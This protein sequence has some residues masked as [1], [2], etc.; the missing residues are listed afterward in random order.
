MIKLQTLY[1]SFNTGLT[2][3]PRRR[4]CFRRLLH[5]RR[6]RRLF[7]LLRRRRRRLLRLGKFDVNAAEVPPGAA[8][9]SIRD[10]AF[11]N[12]KSGR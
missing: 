6:R 10:E 9:F 8:I 3:C 2:F 4:R 5:R 12:G 1:T 11:D 7:I